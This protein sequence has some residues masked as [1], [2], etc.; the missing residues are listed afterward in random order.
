MIIYD[1]I[2]TEPVCFGKLSN[3]HPIVYSLRKT[4]VVNNTWYESVIVTDVSQEMKDELVS[5]G[6]SLV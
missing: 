1:S 5:M 4:T 6:Y 2:K 3:R